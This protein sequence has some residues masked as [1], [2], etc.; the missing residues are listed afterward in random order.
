M[1]NTMKKTTFTGSGTLADTDEMAVRFVGQTKSGNAVMITLPRAICKDNIELTMAEKDDMVNALEFEGLY[2]DDDLA[3]D[4]KTEPWDVVFLH[5][6]DA[7]ATVD[8]IVLGLGKFYV[9]DADSTDQT[10]FE[11]VGLTRGGG[12]FTVERE[13]REINADGDPGAVSGR[14]AKEGGRPKLKLNS[15]EILKTLA[16]HAGTRKET[17][18]AQTSGQG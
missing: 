5:P 9:G 18:N 17:T 8:N 15:L 3:S 12:S 6:E 7:P 11:C 10:D 4:D 13:F 14:V 2:N 16:L 1:P